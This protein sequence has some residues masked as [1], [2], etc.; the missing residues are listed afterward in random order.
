MNTEHDEQIELLRDHI[1]QAW[2]NWIET[3]EIHWL[4]MYWYLRD[5]LT[6]MIGLGID[7]R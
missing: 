3:G 7:N 4:G 1:N 2:D 5:K 6:S